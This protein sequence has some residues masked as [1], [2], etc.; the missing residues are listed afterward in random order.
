MVLEARSLDQSVAGVIP[1]TDCGRVCSLPLSQLLGHCRPSLASLCYRS[2]ILVSACIF[3]RVLP[4]SV[5]VQDCA[6]DTETSR[7]EL[8]AHPQ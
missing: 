8:G 2:I 6:F 4:V 5:C 1:S 3:I 7:I